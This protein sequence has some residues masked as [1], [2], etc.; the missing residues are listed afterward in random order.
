[1]K[2]AVLTLGFPTFNR[3]AV[4]DHTL[5]KSIKNLKGL[6]VPV[7]FLISDNASSDNTT[8]VLA[9]IQA[10]FDFIDLEIMSQERNIGFA[11]NLI[12]L[13]ENCQTEYICLISDEDFIKD[14]LSISSLNRFLTVNS[15]LFCS[16]LLLKDG[17][18][19]RGS[20]KNTTI[21]VNN[22][23]SSCSYLSGIV[24]S[25]HFAKT[26]LVRFKTKILEKFFL[27]PQFFILNELFVYDSKRIFY[28]NKEIV[29]LGPEETTAITSNSLPYWTLEQ[30]WQQTLIYHRFYADRL[31]D[32]SLDDGRKSLVKILQDQNLRMFYRLMK[33]AI[34]TEAPEAWVGIRHGVLLTEGGWAL[35]IFCKIKDFFRRIVTPA[36][37]RIRNLS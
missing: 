6:D 9:R 18:L 35:V 37:R 13:I 31:T 36:L 30:R 22:L 15:P 11:G 8:E 5:R 20:R 33:H 4:L 32:V 26:I 28:L 2:D 3:S 10:E 19:Y 7:K 23:R 14:S 34:N 17:I 1:M 21:K 27:Y 24:F 12:S 29:T 25:V 16:S